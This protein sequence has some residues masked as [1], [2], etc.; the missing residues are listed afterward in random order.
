M[1][2]LLRTNSFIS[3]GQMR[4]ARRLITQQ[5]LWSGAV[6][7]DGANRPLCLPPFHPGHPFSPWMRLAPAAIVLVAQFWWG[8]CCCCCCS[9]VSTSVLPVWWS[10]PCVAWLSYASLW[11]ACSQHALVE[12]S[13]CD[14]H[15]QIEYGT[16][17]VYLCQGGIVFASVVRL[18]VRLRTE[19]KRGNAWNKFFLK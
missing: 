5:L 9:L 1:M 4:Q 18:F 8:S 3:F 7:A 2:L 16:D 14:F 6:T 10:I 19:L 17:C 13:Q 15:R 11:I 12:P